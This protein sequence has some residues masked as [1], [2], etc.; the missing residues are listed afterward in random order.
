MV[1]TVYKRLADQPFKVLSLIRVNYE[2]EDSKSQ[3]TIISK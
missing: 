3:M 1:I 2:L